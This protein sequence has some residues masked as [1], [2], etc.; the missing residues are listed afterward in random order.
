LPKTL[1]SPILHSTYALFSRFS[2][3]F[4]PAS[5]NC[6]TTISITLNFQRHIVPFC[7]FNSHILS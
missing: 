6:D 7:A 1:A 4:H 5:R 2:F 3:I